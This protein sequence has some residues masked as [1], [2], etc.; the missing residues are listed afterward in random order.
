MSMRHTTITTAFVAALALTSIARAE[1]GV[2]MPAEVEGYPEVLTPAR[3]RQSLQDV[4]ASVTIITAEMLR[5]FG[6]TSIPDALRLVP[7]MAVTKGSGNDFRINYHGTN[8]LVPRRMN[9]L[10]DGVSAY[11]PLFA[12]VDWANLPIAL[13][14]ID[15]IE[16]VRGPDSAAYGPNSMLA[17]I[18]I[19]SKHPKDAASFFGSVTRGSGGIQ[20]TTVGLGTTLGPT[21][22]RLT[23]NKDGDNGFDTLSRNGDHDSTRM[24]RLNIRSQTQLETATTLDVNVGYVRGT[25]EIAQVAS[26]QTSYPDA[27]PTDAYLSA[28]LSH[29]FS[30]NHEVK[31]S[32]YVWTDSVVQTWNTC[33]PTAVLLPELFA[34]YRANP[35][36][37]NTIVAGRIP[38]GG[39]PADDALAL[40]AVRAIQRLGPRARAPTCSTTNQNLFQ[41]RIDVELQD[42]YVFSDQLR[43]VGGAGARR[44][45]GSSATYL[46]SNARNNIWRLFGNVEYRPVQ[47]LAINLG[48]YAEYDDLSGKS[49]SPRI[50]AN[51][52]LSNTQAVRLVWSQGTRTPDVQEQQA[53]W[54]YS[55]QNATPTLNGDNTVRLYQSA[56][57]PGGLD[58]ERIESIEAGYLL[59]IPKYGVL[60]DAKIFN[61]KLSHLIS[62]KL[63]LT[64]YTPT[65]NGSV[66]LSGVELQT[67]VQVATD[68]TVF[69]NYAYLSNH[70]A[71]TSL[72]STQYSRNSGS[73]GV[74]HGFGNGWSGSLAYYGSSGDGLGQTS[75]G[76][77]DLTLSKNFMLGGSKAGLTL[78]ARRLDNRSESY[79]RDFGPGNV[80]QATYNNRYQ[81]LGQFRVTF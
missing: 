79:F 28:T 29:S 27:K 21:T 17:I 19:I 25:K 75:Y 72:E 43:V 38:S 47:P 8:I 42:T 76:R 24:S 37:A 61:D 11:Q 20:S 34:L 63:Q 80:L 3:L 30:A 54:S 31:G 15:R 4:P 13:D 32:A 59:N 66:R 57:S 2:D 14:D 5:K 18:N 55:G 46:G 45:S 62:E 48:A 50:A 40:A 68:W 52:R 33:L 16:V 10:I 70:E 65:N 73:A 1:G 6:V 67:S 9:V 51:Y 26:G 36:Y 12:R 56:R 44:H 41:R 69:A 71:S 58:S 49:F 60:F 77:S 81:I 35:G 23:A 7:G 22:I 78:I 64:S 74:W 53:D 39:T